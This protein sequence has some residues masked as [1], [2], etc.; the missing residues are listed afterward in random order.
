[1]YRR[2]CRSCA[3]SGNF[4]FL[5]TLLDRS[6]RAG[7]DTTPPMM[8]GRT[9]G[10]QMEGEPYTC[11]LP[12]TPPSHL[13]RPCERLSVSGRTQREMKGPGGTRRPEG[14]RAPGVQRGRDTNVLL[15]AF[16]CFQEQS[17]LPGRGLP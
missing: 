6:I 15:F 14:R 13:R 10:R 2:W 7:G 5:L 3:F 9:G 4:S 17:R 8:D 1:M 12:P 11:P 16:L